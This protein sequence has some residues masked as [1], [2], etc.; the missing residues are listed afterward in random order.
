[1]AAENH[2]LYF[3]SPDRKLIAE[4][5]DIHSSEVCE[6]SVKTSA[7]LLKRMACSG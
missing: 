4:G 1:M 3:I 7:P 5:I 6:K 2:V